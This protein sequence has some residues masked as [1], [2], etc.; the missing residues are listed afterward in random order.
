[1][2]PLTRESLNQRASFSISKC[3]PQRSLGRKG[4]ELTLA[5][6]FA[7]LINP[8]A[9]SRAESFVRLRCIEETLNRERIT[10]GGWLDN[11]VHG[12]RVWS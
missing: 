3:K 6:K 5:Q 10:N 4:N 2:A 11:E 7:C 8:S 9:I 12:D 1:M